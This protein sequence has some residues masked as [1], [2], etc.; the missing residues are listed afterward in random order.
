MAIGTEGH[1]LPSGPTQHARRRAR[2]VI[3]EI[4]E[5]WIA[6]GAAEELPVSSLRDRV[7]ASLAGEADHHL[8]QILAR[9]TT[10]LELAAASDQARRI[11]S[12]LQQRLPDLMEALERAQDVVEAFLDTNQITQL[13]IQ[14]HPRPFDLADNLRRQVEAVGLTEGATGL[15]LELSPTPVEADPLK[16]VDSLLHTVYEI[17]DLARAGQP[18]HVSLAAEGDQAVG[19][20]GSKGQG[21]TPER[22]LEALDAP[23]D[24]EQDAIDMAYVRAVVER[25]DGTIT[26]ER[27]DELV[28]YGFKLPRERGSSP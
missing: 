11:D 28:G 26:V 19:F 2:H 22:L 20:I 16:L 18:V 7:L 15:C 24:L 5:R 14:L 9:I 17:Q 3:D 21:L 25:H 10:E 4:V 13:L 23:L 1:A 6:S 27:R 12:Q 8:R